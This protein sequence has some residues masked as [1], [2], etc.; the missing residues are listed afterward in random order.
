MSLSLRILLFSYNNYMF[1]ENS[2][3]RKINSL[4]YNLTFSG[5]IQ[6]IIARLHVYARYNLWY[7]IAI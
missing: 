4:N 3:D 5:V 2:H 7:L 1:A 6:T